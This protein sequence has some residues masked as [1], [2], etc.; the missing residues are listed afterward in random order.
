MRAW[1]IAQDSQTKS[2]ND[3]FSLIAS[4][5]DAQKIKDKKTRDTIRAIQKNNV[6]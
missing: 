1:Q 3:L 2:D 6:D 4:M 5:L